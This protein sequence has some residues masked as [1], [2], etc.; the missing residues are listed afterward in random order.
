MTGEAQKLDNLH[1]SLSERFRET[2]SSDNNGEQWWQL[3]LKTRALDESSKI[4]MDNTAKSHPGPSWQES[5]DLLSGNT[6][7]W[8][9]ELMGTWPSRGRQVLKEG[10]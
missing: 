7:L 8:K 5:A 10:D 6:E 9:T 2:N 3:R 1:H 4:S